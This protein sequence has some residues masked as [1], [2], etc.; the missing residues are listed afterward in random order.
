MSVR[1]VHSVKIPHADEG[2]AEG[3]GNIFEFVKD[4]HGSAVV[5]GQWLESQCCVDFT[6]H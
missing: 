5:S 6:D 1:P 2:R 3:R 4:V